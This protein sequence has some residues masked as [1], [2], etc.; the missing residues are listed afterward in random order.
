[1]RVSAGDE[2]AESY[3][4]MSSLI[5]PYV[6]RVFAA[7]L[8]VAAGGCSTDRLPTT[9]DLPHVGDLPFVHKIDIQQGNVVTQEMLAQ[10]QPGMDKKKVNFVMGSPVIMDT[11][12]ADRWDYL[13]TFQPGDG[14]AERR[15][16]TLVF[17]DDKLARVEGDI[18]PAA[19]RLVVD[20]R[21]DMTVV[22]P[23][24]YHPGLMSKLKS[25][26]PFVGDKKD[27]AKDGEA[28][29]ADSDDEAKPEPVPEVTVPEGPPPKKKKKGF[30]SRI[31]GG[32][33]ED[34]DEDRNRAG[35]RGRYRDLTDPDTL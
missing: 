3:K 23:G 25:T 32:D 31:F 20:T 29:T 2:C 12:H 30:F 10:L 28:E 11:F 4:R 34:D 1:M 22:V 15:R 9:A 16:I 24:E 26:I 35:E 27:K 33:D 21:Q 19:G 8:T 18:V 17:E 6:S 5:S 13:Y 7:A 14:R